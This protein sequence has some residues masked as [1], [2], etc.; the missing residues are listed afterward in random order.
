MARSTFLRIVDPTDSLGLEREYRKTQGAGTSIVRPFKFFQ[1]FSNARPLR[2][3]FLKL[4]KRI[5]VLYDRHVTFA[6]LSLE[7]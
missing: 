4:K 2:V 3:D 1:D 5:A 7:E 6:I